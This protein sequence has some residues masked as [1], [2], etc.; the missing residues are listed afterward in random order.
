MSLLSSIFKQYEKHQHEI[1][2]LEK[3]EEERPKRRRRS[4]TELEEAGMPKGLAEIL[5]GEDVVEDEKGEFSV[6]F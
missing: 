5:E 2:A 4:R 6:W 1:E 3:I